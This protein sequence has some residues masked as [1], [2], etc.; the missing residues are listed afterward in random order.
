MP[1]GSWLPC[2]NDALGRPTA[3]MDYSKYAPKYESEV[4]KMLSFDAVHLGSRLYVVTQCLRRIMRNSV[5][6]RST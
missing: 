5:R 3:A 4:R 1:P 6:L 2:A